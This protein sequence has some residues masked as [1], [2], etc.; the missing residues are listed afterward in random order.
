MDLL[1]NIDE[2]ELQE[3]HQV[4]KITSKGN[5]LVNLC[6]YFLVS[7]SAE[8]SIC[9]EAMKLQANNNHNH[10]PHHHH[11]HYMTS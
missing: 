9:H 4:E 8:L 1:R 11:Y 6:T 3:V 2:Q 10:N 7:S 5:C